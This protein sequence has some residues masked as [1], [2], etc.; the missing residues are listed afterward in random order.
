MASG[1][2]DNDDLVSNTNEMY[3]TYLKRTRNLN[4]MV[5]YRTQAF[6]Y[7]DISQMKTI[8]S[9][10]YRWSI[11]DRFYKLANTFFGDAELWWIIAMFNQT[12]TEAFVRAG[13]IIYVPSDLDQVLS[14]FLENEQSY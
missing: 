6:G 13:D 11:G 8:S 4:K 3:K 10:P 7:P 9:L 14:Y 2:Y 12:P 5:H 1:R